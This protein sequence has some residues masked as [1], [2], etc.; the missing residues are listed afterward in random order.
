M[1]IELSD[2]VDVVS[3]GPGM[4]ATNMT[5]MKHPG[6]IGIT[7]ETA[8]Y[9]AC[10]DLGCQSISHGTILHTLSTWNLHSIHH[11][12]PQFMIYRFHKILF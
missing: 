5:N 6:P 12:L 11:S 10:K 4:V 3:Y 2:Y 9:Q 8:S 1:E 7:G